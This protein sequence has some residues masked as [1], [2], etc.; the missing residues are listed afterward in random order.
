M[1][2]PP[3]EHAPWWFTIAGRAWAPVALAGAILAARL[4]WLAFVSPLTLSED[5]AHYW[6]WSQHPGWSYYSKGPGVAW[7]IAAST[8]L[9][10]DTQF[11]VRAP[12]AVA[13][14]LGTL[15][16][17]AATRWA[18]A[19]R[20]TAFTS[21]VLYACIPGL[22]L[23]GALMTIDAPYAACWMWA[24]ACALHAARTGAATATA[25]PMRGGR[26]PRIMFAT[27]A[28][29]RPPTFV[30]FTTGFLEAGYRRFIERRLREEFNFDGSPVRVSVR[31]R[32]KRERPGK[33]NNR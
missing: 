27:Q 32:E 2:E 22:A 23:A 29:T 20:V 30:L 12:A 17:A 13:T 33:G 11:A 21:A 31:I 19:D 14:A 26:L 7:L 3:R 28:S 25:P 8:A 9:F 6:L 24:G 10:G 5:E 4:L 18:G 16:A 1:P 15:G